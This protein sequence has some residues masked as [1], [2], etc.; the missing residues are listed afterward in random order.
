MFAVLFLLV[1]IW[2]DK[3]H[4]TENSNWFKHDAQLS[5]AVPG[6][7]T[8]TTDYEHTV[9]HQQDL[10]HVYSAPGH[11][12]RFSFQ[13]ILSLFRDLSVYQTRQCNRT[14]GSASTVKES[15]H[16]EVKNLPARSPGCIFF[17]KKSWRPFFSF[18]PSKHRPTTSFHRQNKRNKAVRC[19]IIFIFCSHY[20]WSKAIRRARQ[21]GARA[22]ARVV[23]LPARSFDFARPGVAPPLNRACCSWWASSKSYR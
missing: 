2:L 4:Y 14:S 3:P 11:H 20:Y 16:F 19:G 22:C 15:G 8:I 23:D 9:V 6:K 1:C 21:D 5:Y 13:A 7:F 18:H 17:L 10:Q 12:R